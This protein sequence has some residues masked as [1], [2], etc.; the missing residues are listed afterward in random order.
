MKQNVII[1]SCLSA[2]RD[3]HRVT[4]VFFFDEVTVFPFG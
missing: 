3:L 1:E 2:Q 4:K